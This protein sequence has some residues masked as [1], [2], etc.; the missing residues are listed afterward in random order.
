LSAPEATFLIL[1][2]ADIVLHGSETLWKMLE[3]LEGDAEANITVDRPFK[4]LAF[5]RRKS[6]RLYCIRSGI[7][8]KI[9][10]PRDLAAC[11]D[12]FIKALV[13][14]DFLSGPTQPQRIRLAEG[15]RHVFSAYTSVGQVFRNQ[16]RQVLGQT[17]VHILIDGCL[18]ELPGEERARLAEVLQARDTADPGWIKRLIATHL[19]SRRFFWQLYPGLPGNEVRRLASLPLSSKLACFPAALARMCFVAAAGVAARR[20]LKRGCTDYWPKAPQRALSLRS[21]SVGGTL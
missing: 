20:M 2:D 3:T 18:K 11:E 9:Y 8:R 15:A 12:G 4:E 19:R 6:P 7:A 1:M 17:I 16:K 13:C 5:K 10:L 21:L 14:S